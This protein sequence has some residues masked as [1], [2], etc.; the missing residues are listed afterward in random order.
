[1]T[2]RE[3]REAKAERLRGWAEKRETE[4]E[5]VFAAGEP[6]RRDWAFVTQPGHIPERARLIARE[7]RAAASVA[8]AREM[9]SKAANIEAAAAGAVYSD[10][11]DAVEQ[12][13]ARLAALEAERARVKAYNATCRKGTP[14][15]SLL[16]DRQR[17][18]LDQCIAAWGEL[19]CKGGAFPAY[20]LSNL[21]GRISATKKRLAALTQGPA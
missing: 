7:D 20:H 11:P 1:M 4:A 15:R 21:S 5:Q 19:Q 6:M 16:D 14:N 13:T 18:D 2:Y 10:D 17:A 8:K 12:L 3:R 9:R